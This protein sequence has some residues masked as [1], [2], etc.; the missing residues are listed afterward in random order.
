MTS[1]V[2]YASRNGVSP[3]VEC[4]V[5]PQDDPIRGFGLAVGLGM[6]H[7]CK[8]LL[9]VNCDEELT[10]LLIRELRSVIC[11]HDL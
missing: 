8:V 10:K 2:P 11:D 7:G 4:G 6:F 9:F 3:I 1:S 5:A